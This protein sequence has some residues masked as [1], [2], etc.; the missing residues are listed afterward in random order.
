M[1]I[2]VSVKTRT[3]QGANHTLWP[4]CNEGDFARLEVD[5]ESF[6]NSSVTCLGHSERSV[7]GELIRRRRA[8]V[9]GIINLP[10]LNRLSG[11]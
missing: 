6:K 2:M 5:V 8:T 1:T 9:G 11:Q 3:H 4:R 10:L 7:Q